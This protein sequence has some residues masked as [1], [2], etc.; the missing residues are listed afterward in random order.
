MQ[1]NESE[2][3]RRMKCLGMSNM[4]HERRVAKVFQECKTAS[5]S[6]YKDYIK[7]TSYACPSRDYVAAPHRK[8]LPNRKSSIAHIPSCITKFPTIRKMKHLHVHFGESS[9]HFPS[10]IDTF[11][12]SQQFCERIRETSES[13]CSEK[14]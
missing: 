11:D 5:V 7:S 9:R 3:N 8:S 14:Y 13:E 2:E 4:L 6:S 10:T 1:G 12:V